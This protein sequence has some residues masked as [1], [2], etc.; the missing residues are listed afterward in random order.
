MKHLQLAILAIVCLSTSALA[1]GAP[2][3]TYGAAQLNVFDG[4]KP[5]APVSDANQ[6]EPGY[7]QPVWGPDSALLG[8]SR[9][10]YAQGR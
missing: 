4:N 7:A 5:G 10:S 6:C 1:Q 8:Y 2:S 3:A 9:S